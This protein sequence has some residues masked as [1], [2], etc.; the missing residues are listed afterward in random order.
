MLIPLHSARWAN[1]RIHT[2]CIATNVRNIPL[3]SER[4][5][6]LN[7]ERRSD[8]RGDNLWV[9]EIVGCKYW[10]DPKLAASTMRSH[11]AK[12]VQIVATHWESLI[13]SLQ[14]NLGGLVVVSYNTADCTHVYYDG[15]M[16]LHKLSAI[17]L[18]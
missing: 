13:A 17:E 7:A 5:R 1:P 4:H 15:A 12:N 2:W 6:Q 18:R 14:M 11:L 8:P 3:V 10:R 16:D 9:L